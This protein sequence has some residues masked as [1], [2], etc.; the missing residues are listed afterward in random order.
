MVNFQVE[1]PKNSMRKHEA[2]TPYELHFPLGGFD[3]EQACFVEPA[4]RRATGLFG[5]NTLLRSLRSGAKESEAVNLETHR[6][7][8]RLKCE[9]VWG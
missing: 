3:P 9:D 8:A 5:V 4:H 7:L 6:M 1:I 2:P